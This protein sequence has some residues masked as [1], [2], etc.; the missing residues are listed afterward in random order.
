MTLLITQSA[1]TK[2]DTT[3]DILV[4]NVDEISP[5]NNLPANSLQ[6]ITTKTSKCN[7]CNRCLECLS[8]FNKEKQ[9]KKDEK[10]LKS[11]L[12]ALNFMSFI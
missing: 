6:L 8:Q 5:T 10:E 1:N 12:S 11:N 4:E 9:E 7:F 2:A 3:R